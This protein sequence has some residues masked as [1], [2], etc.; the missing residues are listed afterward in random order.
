MGNAPHAFS[1]S[2][3]TGV[4]S[5]YVSALNANSVFPIAREVQLSYRV[6]RFFADNRGKPCIKDRVLDDFVAGAVVLVPTSLP[7]GND[8]RRLALANEITHR[9]LCFVIHRNFAIGI[10]KKQSFRT[11]RRGSLLGRFLLRT[12]VLLSRN[13]REIPVRPRR[14]SESSLRLSNEWQ[15][16]RARP[17]RKMRRRDAPRSPKR[18]KSLDPAIRKL[19]L[20]DDLVTAW[21]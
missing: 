3:Q 19:S 21:R 2:S 12:S 15:R 5:R 17:W 10:V 14:D 18:S 16:R 20:L 7:V 11:K 6:R 1:H 4:M 9:K 13:C 8:C